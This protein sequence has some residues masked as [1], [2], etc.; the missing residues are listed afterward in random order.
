MKKLKHTH[1]RPV[2]TTLVPLFCFF[3]LVQF[4]SLIVTR[5][6]AKPFTSLIEIKN[7][8]Q[9]GCCSIQTHFSRRLSGECKKFQVREESSDIA[10]VFVSV[11][12]IKRWGETARQCDTMYPAFHY[13]QFRPFWLCSIRIE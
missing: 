6:H 4:L 11:S 1:P 3:F 8:T 2:V 5:R 10:I 9:M 7:R 12:S 13:A